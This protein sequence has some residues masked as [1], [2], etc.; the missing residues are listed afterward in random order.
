MLNASTKW[1]VLDFKNIYR[2]KDSLL[3]VLKTLRND[4]DVLYANPF[5]VYKDGTL[6]GLTNQLIVRLKTS[7]DIASL[8]SL[9]KQFNVIGIDKNK[10]IDREYI[11]TINTNQNLDALD[12]ADKLFE[13]GLFD[14]CE[15]D[16]VKLGMFKTNDPV[17][18]LQWGVHN[19]GQYNGTTNADINVVNAWTIATGTGI[20]VAVL[21]EGVDLNQPDLQANLLSGYDA[22]G[23]GSNGA[24]T[25]DDA[26]GTACAGI[27]AAVANNN[28]G[29]TGVA[30]SSK[31]I[32]VRIGSNETISITAS[33]A[34]INWAASATGGNADILSCSWGGGSSSSSLN[35]AISNAISNGRAGKGCIVLFSSGNDNN[36]SI[37]YPSNQP[38]VIAVGGTNPCDQRFII[39]PTTPSN[40]C[41][42]DTRLATVSINAGSNYG[43]GLGIVSPG[44]NIASTDITGTAGF[45][46]H[47]F[48][49]G[50]I[51]YN[52]DYVENF[53]GTSA[54][55]PFAAGVIAL[56]LSV[57]PNLTYSQATSILESTAKKVGGYNYSTQLTN[58]TWNNEMGYGRVDA[59]GAL[60]QALSEVLNISGDASFCT[61]SN[62][63]SIPNLPTGLVVT[64]SANPDLVQFSCNPCNSPILTN[65][66]N[67]LM[68][69]TASIS[70]GCASPV[71]INKSN[72][73][74]GSA[75]AT[76]TYNS[77]TKSNEIMV[78]FGHWD[79]TTFNA[80]CIA[81]ETNIS[82]PGATNVQW[83]GP[84]GGDVYW[85]Q[86]GDNIFCSFSEVGQTIVL[87][88]SVTNPCGGTTIT[89]YRFKCTTTNTC[90]IQP[91]IV[92][93][94]PNPAK[95]NI[96]VSLVQKNKA[97][98]QQSFQKI[99]IIDK[100]GIIK[101][102]NQYN[103]GTKSVSINISLLTPDVYTIQV[104]DGNT[105][106]SE[107]FI[108]N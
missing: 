37:N 56:I 107:K 10:Y 78:P 87:S 54:S 68:T 44:I 96:N 92:V 5:L 72:I 103:A 66:S 91:L 86:S 67:G 77:P 69:L 25:G 30:Y 22:L 100:M 31:I 48:D 85:I 105:W 58:G 65:T 35:T 94:A 41:N 43:T 63:Y 70:T 60:T 55:C 73:T 38:N 108:K 99:R 76:G 80:S 97:S 18:S 57:N 34:G 6:Q 24:P 19:T 52:Q 88:L 104:F 49:E 84:T 61:T 20:K 102:N 106:Y 93:I 59:C 40:S 75:P 26:H 47:T 83:I 45:S 8:S 53:D 27:I 50:W 32:P 98:V 21:D 74:V 81:F 16:F 14:Y 95:T 13:T 36:S 71:I 101:Q 1:N 11:L 7:T 15:P 62:P 33:I 3:S 51:M 23:L 12:I 89:N 17:Y 2:N 82:A 28:I 79:L 46:N 29:V 9:F 90:G 4:T 42:Y 64:W 39:T